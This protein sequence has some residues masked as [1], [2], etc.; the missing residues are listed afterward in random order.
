[1]FRHK[2]KAFDLPGACD[3]EH[4]YFFSFFVHRYGNSKEHMT[5]AE[6]K[7][8]LETEQKVKNVNCLFLFCFVLFCFVFACFFFF[9]FSVRPLCFIMD[10][11]LP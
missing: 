10:L 5:V 3:T 7:M 8:F 6:L 4:L 1:M 11:Y 2:V 9:S